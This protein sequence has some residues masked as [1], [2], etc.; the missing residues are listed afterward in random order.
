M[1]ECYWWGEERRS[2]NR[3]LMERPRAH[4][5]SIVRLGTA[6]AYDK[7]NCNPENTLDQKH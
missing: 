1:G 3:R 5:A 4:K 7:N 6:R 2:G